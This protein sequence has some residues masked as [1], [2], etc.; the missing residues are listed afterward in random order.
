MLDETAR[1]GDVPKQ[2]QM[3]ARPTIRTNILGHG[4][5]DIGL[6]LEHG[7]LAEGRQVPVSCLRQTFVD[8][9]K[10]SLVE[11][12]QKAVGQPLEPAMRFLIEF[13]LCH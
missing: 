13:N 11:C 12:R 7:V 8:G 6:F 9:D 5:K 4:K 2:P 3:N 1:T 10:V